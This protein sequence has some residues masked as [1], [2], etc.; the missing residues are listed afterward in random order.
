MTGW[1]RYGLLA[2]VTTTATV[3]WVQPTESTPAYYL[4]GPHR[5]LH[6]ILSGEQ[7]TGPYFSHPYQVMVYVMAAKVEHVLYEQPCHCRCDLA[8][9]HK[10]LHSC[11]E[12]THG[13]T[14][15]TCMREAV[16]AYQQTKLGK[17]PE[18]IRA[19]IERGDWKDVDVQAATL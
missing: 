11:F 7:L 2:L 5:E 15:A 9:Q 19:G 3:K 1:V 10:S 6:P 16:Y 14:C 8:L 17:S 13:A 4:V 18:E 12:G